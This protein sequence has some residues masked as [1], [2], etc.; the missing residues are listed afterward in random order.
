MFGSLVNTRDKHDFSSIVMR[1]S[2]SILVFNCKHIVSNQLFLIAL[3]YDSVS[4]GCKIGTIDYFI[5]II[6]LL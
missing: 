3:A 1:L 6:I 2:Q 5:L 4:K